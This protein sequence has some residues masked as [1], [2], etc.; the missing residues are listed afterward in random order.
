M[1]LGS[2]V[3]GWYRM[4][5]TMA[6]AALSLLLLF[7]ADHSLLGLGRFILRFVA[8][9]LLGLVLVMVMNAVAEPMGLRV[10]LNPVTALTA[11]CLGLPGMALIMVLRYVLV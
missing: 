9:G 2:M 7:G 11:G 4:A 10:G 3:E 1:G 5:L 6:V 8:R